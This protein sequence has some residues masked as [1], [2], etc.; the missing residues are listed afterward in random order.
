MKKRKNR[1][2][3]VIVNLNKEKVNLEKKLNESKLYFKSLYTDRMNGMISD[4]DFSMLREEYSSDVESYQNRLE[5]IEN[6]LNE[7]EKRKE[8]TKDVDSILKKYTH[9]EKLTRLIVEEFIEK[10][11]I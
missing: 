8:N 5:E 9:I 7:V 2:D 4:S 1:Q 3:N 11:Y 10:I 6:Q